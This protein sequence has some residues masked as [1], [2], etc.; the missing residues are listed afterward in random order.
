M[1]GMDVFMAADRDVLIA[2]ETKRKLK[3]SFLALY[4]SHPISKI[5]IKRIADGAG[6]SRGTFYYY[7]R[8]IYNLLT[9]IEDELV[10]GLDST[11]RDQN[12]LDNMAS[13]SSE[14]KLETAVNWYINTLD[15]LAQN[16]MD[17]LTLYNG[18]DRNS[19]IDKMKK[20]S[21]ENLKVAFEYIFDSTGGAKK[22]LIEY[23]SAGS[24]ASYMSWLET[25][26]EQSPH[27]IAAVIMGMMFKVRDASFPGGES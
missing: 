11:V 3:D 9:E 18:S 7:Y 21:R 19:F 20:N 24:I 26:M 15:F 22:Y 13:G 1:K 10:G 25:G 8:D 23:V 14:K 17:F 5:S 2:E 16:R 12:I 27:E 6:L 4:K